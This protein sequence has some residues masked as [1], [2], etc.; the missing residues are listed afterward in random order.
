MYQDIDLIIFQD[1]K[2][3]FCLPWR[4]GTKEYVGNLGGNHRA[5][6][7]V[8]KACPG[9]VK[10]GVGSIVV[11]SHVGAMHHFGNFAVDSPGCNS[12]VLPYF[13]AFFRDTA[14]KGNLFFSAPK[15]FKK[16]VSQIF[17]NIK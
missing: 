16:D 17:C 14:E 8:S 10:N 7:T 2:V 3:D 12:K 5:G 13:F 9:T 1:A 4:G 11:T 15:V 6:P